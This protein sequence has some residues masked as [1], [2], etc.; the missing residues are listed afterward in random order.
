M[1]PEPLVTLDRVSVGYRHHVVLANL[2]LQ[3]ERGS[4]TALLGANGSGKSTLLKTLA[5]IL[6]PL[7]GEMHFAPGANGALRLGYVP[8]RESLD[9]IFLLSG[10]EVAH[11]GTFRRIRL[12]RI[13]A[14]DERERVRQCLCLA[15]ADGFAARQFSE[16]SGGQ[17]Q[18]VLLARALAAQ[19]DLLL[20]DEPTA[21]IDAA[22]VQA[23][24]EVLTQLNREQGLTILLVSHDLAAVRRHV[25]E[26]AWLH[27]GTLLRGP[28]ADLLAPDKVGELLGLHLG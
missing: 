3:L 5:G 13:V 7:A 26:V 2:E 27:Q 21:G 18:R 4:F 23:I 25:R 1:N 15:G 28:V 12:G 20:L 9:P 17:K 10:F 22:A 19:P 8:Q 6:P 24:L 16:L 11:M 14:R